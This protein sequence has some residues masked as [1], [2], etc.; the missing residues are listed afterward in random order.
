MIK[1]ARDLTDVLAG[2]LRLQW[3]KRNEKAQAG[4]LRG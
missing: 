1:K 4:R 3:E 2:A